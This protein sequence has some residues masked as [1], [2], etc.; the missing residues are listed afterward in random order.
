ME[1]VT[2]RVGAEVPP[3]RASESGLYAICKTSGWPLRVT[4]FQELADLWRHETRVVREC[5]VE[6]HRRE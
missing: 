5:R 3:D 4:L 6:F 1:R 2:L